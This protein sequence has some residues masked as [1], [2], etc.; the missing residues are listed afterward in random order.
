MHSIV[1]PSQTG[2]D[3]S[4]L[5]QSHLLLLLITLLWCYTACH[6]SW[7][8]TGSPRSS[9]VSCELW[10]SWVPAK[11]KFW[12]LHKELGLTGNGSPLSFIKHVLHH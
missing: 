5:R 6:L 11:R 8:L 1:S 12:Q 7:G 10:I 3:H 4:P 2:S 9:G